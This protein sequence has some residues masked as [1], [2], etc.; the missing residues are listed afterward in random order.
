MTTLALLV[1]STALA[2]GMRCGS[3]LISAGAPAIEVEQKCGEPFYTDTTRETRTYRKWISPQKFVERRHTVQIERWTYVEEGKLLR[4]ALFENGEL[5]TVKTEG[6][7]PARAS[8]IEGC[9]KA[10]HSK[11]DTTGEVVLRCGLPDQKYE[12]SQ[13]IVVGKADRS[14]SIEVPFERWIYNLGPHRFLRILT[15]RKGRLIEK[16]TGRRGWE[17]G[18]EG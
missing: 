6:R 13:Q 16:K 9:Q 7:P 17:T 2:G 8:N 15:F 5:R 11:G 3:H 1:P 18:E 4:T 10:I 12:W 14:R